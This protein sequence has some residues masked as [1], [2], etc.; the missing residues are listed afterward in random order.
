MRIVLEPSI[1][2][3]L[4]SLF[5]DDQTTFFLTRFKF[6]S[7]AYFSGIYHLK[8]RITWVKNQR[9]NGEKLKPIGVTCSKL[10]WLE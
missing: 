8:W 5:F 9:K 10:D 7:Q 4:A 3:V 1:V 2:L 6:Q